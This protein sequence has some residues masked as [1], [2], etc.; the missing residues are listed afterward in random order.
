MD[1]R[2]CLPLRRQVGDGLGQPRDR[3]WRTMPG[4]SAFRDVFGPPCVRE[5][6]RRLEMISHFQRGG[7]EGTL[8]HG[9]GR[10]PA[11]SGTCGDWQISELSSVFSGLVYPCNKVV[12]RATVW[13]L[14]MPYDGERSARTRPAS[15]R[16]AQRLRREF[17]AALWRKT[18][19]API[20]PVVVGGHRRSSTGAELRTVDPAHEGPRRGTERPGRPGHSHIGSPAEARTSLFSA[21][22]RPRASPGSLAARPGRRARLVLPLLRLVLDG[23]DLYVLAPEGVSDHFLPLC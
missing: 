13:T 21:I 5:V 15:T 3:A 11:E 20:P 8:L 17:G 19:R 23:L 14:A 10:N 12:L 1:S 16:V 9:S 18:K 7:T 2:A 22:A 4:R 6:V